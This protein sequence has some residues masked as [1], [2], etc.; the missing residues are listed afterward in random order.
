MRRVAGAVPLGVSLLV[1]LG[2]VLLLA[3]SSSLNPID[4]I[5]GRG[6]MVTV[7]DL[8]ELAQPRAVAEAENVGLVPVIEDG[9]SLTAPRGTVIGQSPEA[10][11]RIREGEEV[12]IT[13]SRGAK[14]VEMPDAVGRPL[15]EISPPFEDAGI[16]IEVVE[17]AD[18]EVAAGLVLSQNP[19][20]GVVVTGED[21]VRFEVSTGADDRPVPEVVGLTTDAAAFEL[22]VAG[23]TLG[24]L[25]PTASD[26][27]P[28]GAVVSTDPAPGTVV[29]KDTPVKVVYS[30]GPASETVPDVVNRTATDA[31][32]ALEALGYEVVRA[33]RLV[34]DAPGSGAGAVFE[35][36]PAAG[37][38]LQPGQRVTIVVGRV[39][40]PPPPTTVA[41][42]TTA[43]T[44]TAPTTTAPT[45]GRSDDD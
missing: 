4:A 23:L 9:F 8:D 27:A 31:T 15:E 42:T 7:P 25:S 41:P 12:T 22:G 13:V 38:D 17:V 2:A 36:Y 28:M 30:L 29:E 26:T 43:S 45:T 3:F 16:P 1:A 20:P 40:P 39:A 33:G 6:A 44:T 14:R 19:A 34:S 32:A 18:E 24:E 37:A 11:T 21:T 35:Q 5:L 10:G